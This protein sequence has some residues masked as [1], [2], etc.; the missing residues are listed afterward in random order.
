[1]MASPATH[2]PVLIVEDD[3]DL[4]EMMAQLLTLEGY[5]TTTVANG[6]EALEYLH[7]AEKPHLILL[8][9]MMPVMDGWEF[10]RQQQADPALAPVPVIVLSAL[11]QAR[12]SNLEAEAFLKKPL[13]FDRLLSLVRTYCPPAGA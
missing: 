8:D 2:C 11:D 5:Q 1:M 12:A 13:D 6:R 4:R 3:E 7:D 10:R 9:L